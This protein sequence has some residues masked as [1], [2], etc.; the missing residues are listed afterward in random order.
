MLKREGNELPVAFYSRILDPIER[1]YR[2]T[3]LEGLA[4]VDAVEQPI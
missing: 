2:A 3:E 4:V 1:W